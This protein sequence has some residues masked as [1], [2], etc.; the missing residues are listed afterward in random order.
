MFMLDRVF[1]TN[2]MKC[3]SYI[4]ISKSYILP[5]LITV[6]FNLHVYVTGERFDVKCKSMYTIIFT[7]PC[8]FFFMIIKVYF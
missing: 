5:K 6:I 3:F 1:T 7:S 2:L 8:F 4:H